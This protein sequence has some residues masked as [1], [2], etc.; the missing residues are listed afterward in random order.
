MLFEDGK[1]TLLIHLI[2]DTEIVKNFT[3]SLADKQPKG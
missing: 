3:K 2:N 1:Q